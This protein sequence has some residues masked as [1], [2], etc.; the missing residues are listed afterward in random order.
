MPKRT[1]AVMGATGHIGT[2]I[3]HALLAKGHEV[4]TLGRDSK[5]LS[6]LA[7]I[8]AKI[9]SVAF[10]DATGLSQAFRGADAVFAMI[11]PSY[12]EEDFGAYQSRAG[13]AILRALK[14]GSVSRVVF[15][16]ST[17]AQHPE[18]TGPIKGLHLQERRLTG[19]GLDVVHLR[20][21][22][23]YENHLYGIATIK[24]LG[25]FGTPLAANLPFPQVA[26]QDIGVCAAEFLD[27]LDFKGSVVHEFGGPKDLTMAEVA[28][29]LGREIGKPD[30]A[31]VQFPYSD[32]EQAMIGMGMK[33][34]IVR[35]MI[36]MYRGM[37]EGLVAM[38]KPLSG[39]H[40]GR[41]SIE[42][43]AKTFAAA[44]RG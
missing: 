44:F 36:E 30:L 1:I 40:R 5:K 22:Y 15:L 34:G 33:P 12:G 17:G 38:G 43:F 10:D 24:A 6:A 28:A 41:T 23:F 29:A 4:R 11:P 37:N 16:S 19:A 31:Y 13:E 2:V 3:S 18:G 35:L 26:T 21:S 42:D 27:R 14:G 39:A 32:A 20:P 9:H 8:G 25:V 7:S